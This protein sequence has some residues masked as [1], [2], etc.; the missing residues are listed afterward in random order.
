MLEISLNAKFS[1]RVMQDILLSV[2]SEKSDSI[3]SAVKD[4]ASK[5]KSIDV[6]I[7]N[8]GGAPMA[9]RINSITKVS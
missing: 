1:L 5:Y 2:I 8:A 3:D 6:L 4:I 9:E 7:N